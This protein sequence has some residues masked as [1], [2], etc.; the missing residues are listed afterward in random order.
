MDY[1]I[2]V[3]QIKKDT[4][5]SLHENAWKSLEPFLDLPI[6]DFEQPSVRAKLRQYIEKGWTNPTTRNHHMIKT[7]EFLIIL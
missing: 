2:T 1:K 7:K 6:T 5:S 3:H 4:I